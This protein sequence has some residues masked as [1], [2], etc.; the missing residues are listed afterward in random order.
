MERVAVHLI[1]SVAA[2][3]LAGFAS[4]AQDASVTTPSGFG[5]EHG[6][7]RLDQDRILFSSGR[8]ASGNG[9]D[10][11]RP[12]VERALTRVVRTAEGWLA[13]GLDQIGG[14]Y[15]SR[16]L[17]QVFCI[18]LDASGEPRVQ[19][20]SGSPA[21]QP[22]DVV[23]AGTDEALVA[24]RDS[25]DGLRVYR[26]ASAGAQ[27]WSLP[28][29][30]DALIGIIDVSGRVGALYRT[31]S[32]CEWRRFSLEA[33]GRLR[34]AGVYPTDAFLCD[35]EL[36]VVRDV[37]GS[38]VWLH[39]WKNDDGA[40]YAAHDEGLRD[41]AMVALA[42]E[43]QRP[44]AITAIDGVLY[45]EAGRTRERGDRI[46]AYDTRARTLVIRDARR[47]PGLE[48]APDVRGLMPSADG[49]LFV[50]VRKGPWATYAFT[51]QNGED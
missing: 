44:G 21:H 13:C 39:A 29:G 15:F 23:A 5:G 14:D 9:G 12:N 36:T 11:G 42:G 18:A 19:M 48:G 31:E 40:L 32:G 22:F 26:L 6:L 20:K 33:D 7:I 37:S 10:I 17:G 27:E 16:G 35:A 30:P 8:L 51:S 34:E 3:L 41:I 28:G 50:L 1:A 47:E 2:W 25:R 4:I 45:F 38:G 49:R 24:A 43:G 46:G